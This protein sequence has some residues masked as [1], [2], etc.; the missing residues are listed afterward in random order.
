MRQAS[1]WSLPLWHPLGYLGLV[2]SWALLCTREVNSHLL[3]GSLSWK[4]TLEVS[5]WEETREAVL[6]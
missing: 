5:A 3:S 6:Q 4:L 2:K 1:G